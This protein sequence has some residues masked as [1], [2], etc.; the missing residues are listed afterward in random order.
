MIDVLTLDGDKIAA[1][2]AFLTAST[3]EPRHSDSWIAGPLPGSRMQDGPLS[4]SHATLSCI[5]LGEVP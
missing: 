1:V 2:T 3:S 4:G 5:A